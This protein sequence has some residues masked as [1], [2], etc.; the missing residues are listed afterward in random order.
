MF[1][2]TIEKIKDFV[3]S[4]L[5]KPVSEEQRRAAREANVRYVVKTLSRG[6]TSLQQGLYITESDLNQLREENYNYSFL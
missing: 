4:D 1:K 3:C 6:N 2:K 5:P